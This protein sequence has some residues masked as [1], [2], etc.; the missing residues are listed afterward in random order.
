MA[1]LSI[2]MIAATTA[3]PLLIKVYTERTTIQQEREVLEM[4]HNRTQQY[5]IKKEGSFEGTVTK[6]TGSYHFF[7]KDT[8]TKNMLEL[9]VSWTGA[10]E[11]GYEK[12]GQAQR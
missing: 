4:L 5:L 9:C 3:V 8:G 7:V 2:M 10:N 1:A 12:C 11:R 6:G